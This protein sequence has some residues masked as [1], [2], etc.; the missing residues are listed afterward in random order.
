MRAPVNTIIWFRRDLR[1]TDHP[2]L[3]AAVA[4][5][6]RSG[7]RVLALFIADPSLTTPS[8]SNRL[9]HLRACLEALKADGVPLV[10]RRGDPA[11]V[12]AEIVAGTCASSVYC[13][14]DFGPYGRRR[15]DRVADRLRADGCDLYAVDSPY[16]LPPGTVRKADGTPFKVF[17]PFSRA[18]AQT[19]LSHVP[20]ERCRPGDV[21]WLTSVDDEGIASGIRR[22]GARTAALPVAGERAAAERLHHFVR[23]HL[24]T[25]HEVRNLP[26][27]DATSRLSADLKFGVVH[28]RQ[29]LAVAA[30][31]P[32][33]GARVFRNEL[34]WR[35]FYADVLWHRP[36]TA[37]HEFDERMAGMHHDTG[38][39]ADRRF[40]AWR[41]G[42]TGYPFIDAGMRQLLAEGW[43][44]NRVRMAVASFLVKD[45]HLDWRRG[46]RWFMTELV[47]GDLASNQHGWQWTA[48]TGTDAAPYFRVFN[49]I[50]QGRKFDPDGAY[51]RR[52]LP[53]L[54]HLDTIHVHQPWLA[55][56]T[57]LDAPGS[58]TY[59][60][61]IV[62]H[63]AER[64]EALAR[65]REV[66]AG[67]G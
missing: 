11:G 34:C 38:A 23:H 28:P 9:D 5:A 63:L 42:T 4:A 26:A 52:Y 19:A 60:P 41:T 39:E 33:E 17:T 46:A 7:G 27:A 10:V 3:D 40:E 18:W 55:P 29:L 1:L 25:Y 64:D 35:D 43:M 65:Y 31:H 22:A 54:A 53:E 32:G 58:A 12:L 48:G 49:P 14:A 2:A 62:E 67:V 15:D 57:L 13:T 37:R 45:L 30:N 61:P 50:T 66:R 16:V 20:G 8:G 36:D 47:D 59:P 51:I 6:V 56:P 21:P 44:H 24:R